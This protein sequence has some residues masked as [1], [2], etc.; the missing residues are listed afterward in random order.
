M[1]AGRRADSTLAVRAVLPARATTEPACNALSG[2]ALVSGLAVVGDRVACFVQCTDDVVERDSIVVE[3][4]GH[5]VCIHV[6]RHGVD[7]FDRLDSLTG[8]R[9]CASS[10]DTR[11]FEHIG[12]VLG[13]CGRRAR[14]NEEGS[15]RESEHVSP[16]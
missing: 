5:R 6:S 9:R 13:E 3:A 12:D 1:Q 16:P 4:H 11:R 7:C 15:D 8:R 10:D 14:Q 2:S